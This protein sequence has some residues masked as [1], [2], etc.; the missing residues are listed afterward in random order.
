MT[1][2]YLLITRWPERWFSSESD[3]I[4]LGF[5]LMI[6]VAG[7]LLLPWRPWQKALA[8]L[9]YI[10]TMGALLFGL[11]LLFVCGMFGDCP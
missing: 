3:W 1:G 10:P 11:A 7:H 4:A 8:I 6:G 5:A 9:L 2:V